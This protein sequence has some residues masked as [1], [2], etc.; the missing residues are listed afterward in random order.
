[1]KFIHITDTHM[2]P[3][4]HLIYGQNTQLHLDR[5]ISSINSKHHD[6][7]MVIVTGDLTHW[8]DNA[9]FENL[10]ASLEK[11]RLPYHLLIGNHDH[12]EKFKSYFPMQI[13]TE[14]NST[15]IQSCLETDLGKFIFL[16]TV[17]HG[18]DHGILCDERLHWIDEQIQQDESDIFF[19]M[20]HPPFPL[21]ITSMDNIGLRNA[22]KF[23]ELIHPYRSRIRHIFFGHV[24][25][26]VSGSWMGIPFSSTNSM[27]A[28]INLQLDGCSKYIANKENPRYSVITHEDG[29]TIVHQEDFLLEKEDLFDMEDSPWNDWC[30]APR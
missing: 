3:R 21:G 23:K 2:A 28:Q 5:A 10:H 27:M 7:S 24:H 4:G 8:G 9:S 16:D 25:R 15:F 19:F 11:L 18:H 13:K 6:A 30:I 17:D 1:M 12:R 22:Q 20:H 26:L 29:M 14:T